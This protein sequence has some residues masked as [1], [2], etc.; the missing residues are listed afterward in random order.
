[1]ASKILKNQTGSPIL[2]AD[3]GITIPASPATY[4]IQPTDYLL[5]DASANIITYINNGNIVV[6]DGTQDLS[7]SSALAYIKF[8]LDARSVRFTTQGV[9]LTSK[10]AEAAIDEAASQAQ[11]ALITP[12]YT[13]S[14][15]YNGTV[16]NNTFIGY[17]ANI[18]GDTSPVTIP[19]KARLKEIAYTNKNSADFN[20]EFRIN[21]TGG[22]AFKTITKTTTQF[23]TD[24]TFAQL[25]DAGDR[26]YVKYIS[27][28]TNSQDVSVL[29]SFQAEP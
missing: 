8:P 7:I 14:L 26:I 25:F 3:V 10:N 28:G 15:Q 13:I 20:L 5:W 6:N 22:G 27:T 21:T 1:M 29:L 18:P 23:F 2:I 9:V 24:N 17:A 19:L 11:T 4:T 16:S 12:R